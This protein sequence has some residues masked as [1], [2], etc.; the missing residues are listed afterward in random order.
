MSR[1]FL[2]LSA[3]LLVGGLMVFYVYQ[4]EYREQHA[5]GEMVEVLCAAQDITLGQAVR[6]AWLTTKE[7]PRSYVE[8]RHLPASAMRDLIGLPLAQTVRSGEAILSTD[9]SSF[10]D[11]RRTLSST[12]PAGMR[13]A[14]ILVR[15]TSMFNGL[16][17]P[18]DRVDVVVQMGTRDEP[19]SWRL[20]P[21]VENVLV[22]AIGQEIEVRQHETP[23][24]QGQ[25]GAG[26]RGT[27]QEVRFGRATN[28]TIQVSI[29]QSALITLARQRGIMSLLLRNPNDILIGAGRPEIRLSDIF[30]PARRGQFLRRTVSV[31]QLL[32]QPAVD[33]TAP[34][35]G[36]AT[37]TP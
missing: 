4:Q 34:P 30:D 37:A 22:I 32:Q 2:L 23:E 29:E 8:E 16:L 11:S 26:M 13:A 27:S 1:T 15:A 28:M 18:G 17:R 9:L 7:I 33:P 3:G 6:Q 19:G 31:A 20:V 35:P 10:S 14:T 12:I 5:G 25:T 21:V 24:Q 36:A